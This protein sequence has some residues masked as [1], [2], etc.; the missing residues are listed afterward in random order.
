MKQQI[1]RNT[2]KT[3]ICRYNYEGNPYSFEITAQSFEEAQK[4]LK[5]IGSNGKI[6][7]ELILAIPISTRLNWLKKILSAISQSP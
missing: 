7:G 2:Y 4:R 6:D 5:C 3:Y 1:D